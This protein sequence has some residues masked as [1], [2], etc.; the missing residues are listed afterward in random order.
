MNEVLSPQQIAKEAAA[1]YKAKQF[2][3]AARKYQVAAEAYQAMGADGEA[4]EVLNNASVAYLQAG[5][6]QAAFDCA[7]GTEQ[8]FEELDDKKRAAI[9]YANRAAALEALGE[10]EQAIADY[11]K[12]SDMFKEIGEDEMRL[13]VM[14]SLSALQLKTNKTLEALASMQIG[15]DGLKKPK[16]KYR[17]LK[18]LLKI[19]FK[20]LRK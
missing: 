6:A 4:A 1:Q 9:A 13:Q 15:V 3:D 20:F 14:Q 5:K 17:L 10:A 19:P 8:V 18:Q 16:G 7:N 11:Q 12:S 2:E